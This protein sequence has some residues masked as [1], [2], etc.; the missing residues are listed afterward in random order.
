[1]AVKTG[2][3]LPNTA[4]LLTPISLVPIVKNTKA[5]EDAKKDKSTR[6]DISSAFGLT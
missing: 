3:I 5:N 2:I 1:M 4:V 6:E